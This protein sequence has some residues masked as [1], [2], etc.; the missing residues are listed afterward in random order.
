MY[1]YKKSLMDWVFNVLI[2]DHSFS[3]GSEKPRI[4][5]QLYLSKVNVV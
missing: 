3:F 4:F 2:P 1:F 5:D